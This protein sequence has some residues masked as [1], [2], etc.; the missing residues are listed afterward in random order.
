[1]NSIEERVD[2]SFCLR[3]VGL[4]EY[5]NKYLF[6]H[7]FSDFYNPDKRTKIPIKSTSELKDN[8]MQIE[9]FRENYREMK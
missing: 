3:F 2:E 9:Y 7:R 1:M 6:I 4:L 8:L 5:N